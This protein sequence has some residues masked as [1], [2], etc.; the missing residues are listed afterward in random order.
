MFKHIPASDNTVWQAT[1]KQWKSDT[2]AYG[3]EGVFIVQDIERQLDAAKNE[4]G[5]DINYYFL[6]KK[7]ETVAS[8]LLETSYAMAKSSKP[9]L[10]LL[11]ITLRPS[12]LA[13][14]DGLK[15]AFLVLSYSITHSIDLIFNE[16]PSKELK[17]YGRTVEMLNLFQAIVSAGKLDSVLGK[18]K[19]DARIVGKWLILAKK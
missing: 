1:A 18:Y 19:L 6:V 4:T 10:K 3:D 11:H 12:L 14:L 5:K 15:E 13:N 2:M 9:W 7:E 17:I 16:H 8:S